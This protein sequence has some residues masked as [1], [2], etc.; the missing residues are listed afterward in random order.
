MIDPNTLADGIRFTIA[1]E[2]DTRETADDV[3]IVPGFIGFD[4]NER[5]VVARFAEPLEDGLYR[6]EVFGE[7]VPANIGSA[8]RSVNGTPFE[9]RENGTFRDIV[10]FELE[11]GAKIL[12]VVPQP[13][14]RNP[15]T[16]AL[17]PQRNKI[18]IY[19]NDDDLFASEDPND[20]GTATL[21]RPEFYQ[22]IRTGDTASTSDD[23]I[24]YPS[25]ILV[26]D[27]IQDEIANVNGTGTSTVDVKVNRVT[28][29]FPTTDLANLGTSGS[30]RLKVGSSTPVR[31][32]G[33]PARILQFNSNDSFADVSDTAGSAFSLGTLS[34]ASTITLVTSGGINGTGSTFDYPG[35]DTE[36]GNR[37]IG[38]QHHFL[39]GLPAPDVTPGIEY[40]YYNFANNRPYGFTGS[41]IPLFTAIN[42]EQKERVREIFELYG[43]QFGIQFIETEDARGTTVVVG[44]L[45]PN[46]GTS[47]PGGTLGIAGPA[48][49]ILDIAEPW[50]NEYGTGPNPKLFIFRSC[51]AR[52]RTRSP[53]GTQLRVGFRHHHVRSGNAD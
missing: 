34:A 42:D 27:T 44:D 41:N 3:E 6:V 19:F 48:L 32:Q 46:G 9:P 38:E 33:D 51:H 10:D 40:R 8:L 22:L 15:T 25:N 39:T 4:E 29:T 2:D 43:A 47:G 23:E 35:R 16:E 52:D 11:L 7:D 28:L 5:V 24:F 26:E 1:G 37:D 53:A 20:P 30:F 12:A 13:V 50:F 45:A 17:E 21:K 31:V 14:Q 18:E 49:V 36:P